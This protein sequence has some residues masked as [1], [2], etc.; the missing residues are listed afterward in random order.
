MA[1][2][3]IEVVILAAGKGTRM[4]S[5]QPKVLHQLAGKPLLQ[6]VIDT[7]KNLTSESIHLI[8]GHGADLVKETIVDPQLDWTEQVKQLGTGHAVQQVSDKINPHND[9][10]ILYGDV[11]LISSETLKELVSIKNNCDIALLTAQLQN[12]FGYGRI[13]RNSQGNVEKIV[14]QKDAN[15]SERN[16]QEIN[17]GILIA[18]GSRL[19]HWLERLDNNNAQGE[20]YLTDIIEFARKDNCSVDAYICPQPIEIEGVNNKLQLAKLER[21]IQQKNAENL[22]LRGVTLSDPAR[23]D[24]RGPKN[25]SDLSIGTDSSIDINVIIEGDCSFGE[26]VKI[27]ANCIIKNSIIGDDVV[28]HENSLIENAIVAE[29]CQIGPFARLRPDTKLQP[30]AKVG[31]FVEIKKS[32]IGEG[33]KVNHLTYIGDTIM[34]ENVNIGAG[35]ITCNYDGAYKHQTQ[36]GDNVFVGSNSALVAPVVIEDNAT[37]GAGTTLTKNVNKDSLCIARAKHRSI[38][39]WVRPIKDKG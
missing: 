30:Q 28:I 8:Y 39:N 33:S 36:I 10:L 6:H 19:I 32:T 11:P 37:V 15:E 35:T 2:K 7:A 23:F 24:Y 5:K 21:A 38:E 16:I 9:V 13:V 4:Y 17:S 3:S 14:E 1:V 31:N 12:P 27:G 20:F 25:I 26:R 34:G 18:D 29:Q 22:M